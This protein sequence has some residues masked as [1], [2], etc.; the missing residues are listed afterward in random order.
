MRL[1]RSTL[2]FTLIE[3]ISV[4]IILAVIGVVAA[5][6]LLSITTDTRIARL[7]GMAA[8]LKSIKDIAYG[9]SAIQDLDQ[10]LH[11]R[12][13]LIEEEPEI[14]FGYPYSYLPRHFSYWLNT[15]ACFIADDNNSDL[16]S[17]CDKTNGTF[18]LVNTKDGQYSDW[19]NPKIDVT[20]LT[21]LSAPTPSSCSVV[22][23][24]TQ[25]KYNQAWQLVSPPVITINT[26]GC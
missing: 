18:K 8:A 1:K 20:T 13:D 17:D 25:I 24:Q 10:T 9:Q 16:V 19:D 15:S 11:Y 26:S 23:K 4:I 21:D 14:M 7:E 5:P 12:Y 2:G 6:R 22:Y 3:L